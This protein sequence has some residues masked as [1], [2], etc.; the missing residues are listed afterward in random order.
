LPIFLYPYEACFD[1]LGSLRVPSHLFISLKRIGEGWAHKSQY[2]LHLPMLKMSLKTA[3]EHKRITVTKFL[4]NFIGQAY[5]TAGMGEIENLWPIHS[6]QWQRINHK[7]IARW[8]HLSR[9]KAS[10]F[11]FEFFLLGIKK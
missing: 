10:A 9:L 1:K 8:Q 6:A 11:L 2:I 7:Q 5:F 3:L 4:V